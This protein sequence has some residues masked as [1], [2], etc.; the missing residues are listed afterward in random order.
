[1]KTIIGVF[2]IFSAILNGVT[3]AQVSSINGSWSTY[4]GGDFFMCENDLGEVNGVYSDIGYI[5]GTISG[6][7]LVG[8][9]FQ[10]GLNVA[11]LNGR[12][13]T[14]N[15]GT[16]SF[17]VSTNSFTGS[18]LFEQTV[19]G[20]EAWS[21]TRRNIFSPLSTQCWSPSE[22][23]FKTLAGRWDNGLTNNWDQCIDLTGQW[24][25][26]YEYGSARTRGYIVGKCFFN[27]Q[28]C[29]GDW[30]EPGRVNG[31]Y[32]VRLL[33]NDQLVAS[34]WQFNASDFT[35][36]TYSRYANNP[37][38]HATETRPRIG[39]AVGCSRNSDL[40]FSSAAISPANS[41]NNVLELSAEAIIGI[42]VYAVGS[43]IIGVI[44]LLC[45][46]CRGRCR[47]GRGGGGGGLRWGATHHHHTTRRHGFGWSHR[48]HGG[49][50]A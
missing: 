33:A 8:E 28:F 16:F 49:G 21:G 42:V 27:D 24:T 19:K 50:Y 3:F 36:T 5:R 2:I 43:T 48:R 20:G 46:F 30:Y 7:S 10:T 39:D 40:F 26:S 37:S 13:C 15:R 9:W 4:Y 29:H 34:W 12:C 11:D 38:Y 23:L 31:G 1:M 45:L 6:S 18:Y 44:V 35:S 14:P 47:A 41:P 22:P 25:A 17:S 32:M